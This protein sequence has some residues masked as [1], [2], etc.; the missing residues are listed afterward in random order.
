MRQNK[1]VLPGDRS[2]GPRGNLNIGAL[3]VMG[4][5]LAALEQCISA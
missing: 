2:Q 3:G 4:H 5:W 1:L